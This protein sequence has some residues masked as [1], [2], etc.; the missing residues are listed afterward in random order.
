MNSEGKFNYYEYH[1][2][3]LFRMCKIVKIQIFF[4]TVY[5][6]NALYINVDEKLN[7]FYEYELHNKISMSTFY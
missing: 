1:S 3:R 4:N 6:E 5:F 2:W 7:G